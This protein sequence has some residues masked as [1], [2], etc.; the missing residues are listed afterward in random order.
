MKSRIA[1][2]QGPEQFVDAGET[3]LHDPQLWAAV[4]RNAA[5][6]SES[7]IDIRTLSPTYY[8]DGRAEAA[9]LDLATEN[10]MYA[11]LW[12][13][14]VL[15]FGGLDE[16][17]ER[18][19]LPYLP[20]GHVLLARAGKVTIVNNSSQQPVYFP[21]IGTLKTPDMPK[22][23]TWPA[24]T[25]DLPGPLDFKLRIDKQ[26]AQA[27]LEY[28]VRRLSRPPLA[29][30]QVPLTER[31]LANHQLREILALAMARVAL[32]PTDGVFIA[33]YPLATA[34]SRQSIWKTASLSHAYSIKPLHIDYLNVL[35]T[36]EDS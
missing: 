32:R 2:F 19:S 29:G 3:L 18:W 11:R 21:G 23:S 13:E 9:E 27:D 33:G 22:R 24:P 10:E 36:R 30:E 6:F 14:R 5:D 28:F 34:V 31:W 20:T 7:E 15:D 16:V 1:E 35:R 25:A 12:L 4:V 17:V 8:A 26:T